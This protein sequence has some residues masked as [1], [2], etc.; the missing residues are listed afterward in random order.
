MQHENIIISSGLGWKS[1][2]KQKSEY[3]NSVN[4]NKDTSFPYLVLDVINDNA[5]P[6]N[7]GFQVMHWHEDLQFIYVIDGEIT[8]KTLDAE[9]NLHR[10][11]GAFINKEVVHY[12][13]KRLKCHY[14]SFLFPDY[15]LAFYGGSPARSF[16]ERITENK[17][18]TILHF[19][20]DGGKNSAV[21]E[22]LRG[23]ST[24][25]QQKTEFYV[26]DVLVMLTSL[27]LALCKSIEMPE[28]TEETA[29]A[30]RMRKMLCYMAEH[31]A[32]DISLENLAASANVSKSE[33][34]RCFKES[35]HT[36]PYNYLIELRLA[37]A[38]ELLEST[39]IPIGEIAARVGFNQ[40]SHFGKMFREKT[41][42][43]PREYRMLRRQ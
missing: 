17:D 7:P 36:T 34:A 43:S 23:L 37:N 41:G 9:I 42:C 33:C 11:E 20:P 26:Y 16:V 3:I 39:D 14:N 24:L 35:L 29:T 1:M 32:E 25:E 18:I 19:V 8:V 6:R 22:L 13:G 10:G 2:E 5:Y 30:Q 28:R 15:F 21:L 27:W 38:A 40:L 31:L 12:V 4:L